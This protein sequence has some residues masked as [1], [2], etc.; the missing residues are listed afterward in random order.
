MLV[1]HFLQVSTIWEELLQLI[2]NTLQGKEYPAIITG[3][4]ESNPAFRTPSEFCK[5]TYIGVEMGSKFPSILGWSSY[6]GLIKHVFKL[7]IVGSNNVCFNMNILFHKLQTYFPIVLS[8][9]EL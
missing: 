7:Q 4:A 3:H 1:E 2:W 6:K 8:D 5:L 9:F